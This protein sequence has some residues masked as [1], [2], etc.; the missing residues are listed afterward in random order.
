MFDTLTTVVSEA[1]P[2]VVFNA[3]V[4]LNSVKNFPQG[5]HTV[6]YRA[7][8]NKTHT[9]NIGTQKILSLNPTGKPINNQTCRHDQGY[10]A[11]FKCSLFSDT[12]KP[13]AQ[14]ILRSGIILQTF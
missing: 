11:M 10:V 4:R 9:L 3:E 12:S 5:Y 13:E 7:D 6:N 14:C 1:A 8:T 2:L